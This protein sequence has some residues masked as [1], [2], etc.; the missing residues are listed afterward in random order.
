MMARSLGSIATRITTIKRRRK[1]RPTALFALLEFA[2][3]RDDALPRSLGGAIR[4]HQRPVDV[5]L[6]VLPSLKATQKHAPSSAV[7]LP[8]SLWKWPTPRLSRSA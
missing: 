6:S 1:L 3:I 5:R 7:P 4:F 8:G 2:Q